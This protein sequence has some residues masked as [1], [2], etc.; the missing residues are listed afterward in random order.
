MKTNLNWHQDHPFVPH[1]FW[2]NY[3]RVLAVIAVVIL[4]IATSYV[5]YD[6]PNQTTTWWLP[7]YLNRENW[8]LGNVFDSAMRWCVPVFIMLSGMLLL[9]KDEPAI[10]FYRKRMSRILIPLLFWV[11]VYSLI[12]YFFSEHSKKQIV[13]EALNGTVFYHLWYVYMLLGLY[14]VTPLLRK[15]VRYWSLNH[16]LIFSLSLIFVTMIISPI[17]L[18]KIPLFPGYFIIW[19]IKYIGYYF[20][21]YCFI[22]PNFLQHIQNSIL[23]V[24]YFISIVLTAITAYFMAKWF[25]PDWGM[26]PYDFLSPTVIVMSICVFTLFSK[27]KKPKRDNTWISVL[28]AETLGVYLIHPLFLGAFQKYLGFYLIKSGWFIPIVGLTIATL[29]FAV[30]WVMQRIPGLRW[31]C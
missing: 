18:P 25:G 23:W 24:L 2:A 20:L 22:Q 13:S 29:S 15:W 4:H 30:I 26:Y 31:L 10:V 5:T 12:N 1:I 27:M 28:N 11:L 21:G 14:A 16:L 9:P 6:F 3:A 8:W 7:P 19:T 17:I